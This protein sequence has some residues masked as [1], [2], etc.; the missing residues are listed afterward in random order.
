M[1][2]PKIQN[3]APIEN[4]DVS[5]NACQQWNGEQVDVLRKRVETLKD[6][7]ARTEELIE[8]HRNCQAAIKSKAP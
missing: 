6:E 4:F 7:I 3:L 1:S 2:N 5:L 8:V